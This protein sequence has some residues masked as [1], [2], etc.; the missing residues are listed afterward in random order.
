MPA[1]R[2][3]A[4]LGHV[5]YM[6]DIVLWCAGR[7][8]AQA[9]L[10]ALQAAAAALGLQFKPARLQPVARG[11]TLCG[12]R[13]GSQGL[14]FGRRRQRAWRAAWLMARWHWQQGLDDDASHQRPCNTLRALALPAAA[15]GWR[16]LLLAGPA[17][18]LQPAAGAVQEG[19]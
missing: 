18:A 13:L 16:R 9:L 6:D 1:R 3:A 15:V 4:C 10:A 17:V 11:L 12:F 7:A 5:R 2:G 8:Q 14:R 19:L